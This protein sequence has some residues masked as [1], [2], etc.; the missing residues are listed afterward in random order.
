MCNPYSK[1]THSINLLRSPV[2]NIHIT[3]TIQYVG[4]VSSGRQSNTLVTFRSHEETQAE[5]EVQQI[6]VEVEAR[7]DTAVSGPEEDEQ[8]EAYGY[9]DGSVPVEETASQRSEEEEEVPM[10][11]IYFPPDDRSWVYSPLHYNAQAYS[12]S[13][14]ESDT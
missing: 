12:A 8:G 7:H 5:G 9:T 10:T 11:D 2:C 4:L 1:E 6:T 3:M 14:K 13:D